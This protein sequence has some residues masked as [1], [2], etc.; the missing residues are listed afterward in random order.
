MADN[1]DASDQPEKGRIQRVA[2]NKMTLMSDQMWET[3][4]EPESSESDSDKPNKQQ[5][6]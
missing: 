5:P 6:K 4:V 2:T 3:A 1:F